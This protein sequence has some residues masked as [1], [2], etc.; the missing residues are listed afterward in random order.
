MAVQV[1]A[2]D[3]GVAAGEVDIMRQKLK[4]LGIKDIIK[5]LKIIWFLLVSR[6]FNPFKDV[7]V[8][9]HFIYVHFAGLEVNRR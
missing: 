4:S 9:Y 2:Y 1:R 5:Y 6:V 8:V 3:K 7:H